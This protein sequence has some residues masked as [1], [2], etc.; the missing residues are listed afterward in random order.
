MDLAK[1][2]EKKKRT[3]LMER[4]EAMVIL[5]F[6]IIVVIFEPERTKTC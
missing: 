1:E 3:S 5:N 2:G 4:L 6:A